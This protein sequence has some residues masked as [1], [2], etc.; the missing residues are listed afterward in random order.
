MKIRFDLNCGFR[1]NRTEQPRRQQLVRVGSKFRYSGRTQQETRAAVAQD[2][3]RVAPKVVRSDSRRLRS[4]E[5]VN[6]Y[7]TYD[8]FKRE[9]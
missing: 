9:H 2:E 6:G 3:D 7:A 8:L 5:L 4:G 1:L